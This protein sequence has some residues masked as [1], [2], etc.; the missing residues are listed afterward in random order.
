MSEMDLD[1]AVAQRLLDGFLVDNQSQNAS[2]LTTCRVYYGP[3]AQFRRRCLTLKFAHQRRRPLT[4]V[5]ERNVPL[6]S[7]L[8]SFPAEKCQVDLTPITATL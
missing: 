2:V 1:R 3:L 5:T 8:P 6:Q 4:C 7:P